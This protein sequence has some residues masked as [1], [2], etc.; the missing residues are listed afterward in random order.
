MDL[1]YVTKKLLKENNLLITNENAIAS[2]SLALEDNIDDILLGVTTSIK[3]INNYINENRK[4]LAYQMI[5]D[6]LSYNSLPNHVNLTIKEED[7]DEF[8]RKVLLYFNNDLS[9][10]QERL[11]N[12]DFIVICDEETDMYYMYYV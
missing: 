5:A 3:V 1:N 4:E 7:I 8:S 2:I 6:E 11:S 9:M 12:E 10:L